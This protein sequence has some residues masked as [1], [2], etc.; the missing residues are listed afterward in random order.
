MIHQITRPLEILLVED[1]P[2]DADLAVEA[3]ES[4]NV[5]NNLY[6]VE[7]GV[8]ALRFLR[9]QGVYAE[10]PRPDI[11]LLDL[12]L[13]K[14]SG[15]EVLMEVKTDPDLMTIPIVVLTTSTTEEDVLRSYKLH[16]NCYI[17]KPVDLGQFMRVIEMTEDFWLTVVKLPPKST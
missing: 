5:L 9:Q 14:K 15:C 10:V 13:P 3:F 6:I 4:S 2:T 12:N 1:S 8:E 16:A 11:V 17:A 7:D